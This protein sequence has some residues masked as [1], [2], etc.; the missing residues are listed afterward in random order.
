MNKTQKRNSITNKIFKTSRDKNQTLKAHFL[1]QIR[2]NFNKISRE[3]LRYETDAQ[4]SRALRG[5]ESRNRVFSVT[6]KFLAKD[7]REFT[8]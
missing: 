5:C 6:T 2:F 4:R 1:L 8:T 7:K 3:F